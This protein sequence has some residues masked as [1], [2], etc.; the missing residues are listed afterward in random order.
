MLWI[1]CICSNCALLS[2]CMSLTSFSS[3]CHFISVPQYMF[4]GKFS[5]SLPSIISVLAPFFI[6]DNPLTNFLNAAINS[7]IWSVARILSRSILISLVSYFLVA[8]LLMLRA[9]AVSA[10]SGRTIFLLYMHP[11]VIAMKH[12]TNIVVMVMN[13]I[14]KNVCS[15]IDVRSYKNWYASFSGTCTSTINYYWSGILDGR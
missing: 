8:L 13:I 6:P 11:L 12:V 15:I 5:L 1:F 4:G 14:F 3:W 2:F 7:A 10:A 9:Y